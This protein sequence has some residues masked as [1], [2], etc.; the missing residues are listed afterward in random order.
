MPSTKTF[1][2]FFY[3]VFPQA[4]WSPY[5][6][7][8]R[9]VGIIQPMVLLSFDSD[10]DEDAEAAQGLFERLN[11][12]DIPVTFAVPGA[13]LKHGA[14]IYQFLHKQGAHFINHGGGPHTEFHDGR[15]WSVGFY[16]HKSPAQVRQ[17]I[18]LGHSIFKDV[19]GQE[20]R[21][22]RTPHFGHFQRN[23]DL[24]L[25]HTELN[26][27]GGYAFASGSL[28]YRARR[29]GPLIPM[30]GLLEIPVLGTYAWPTRLF[31]SYG[32]LVSKADR[33]VT[34]SYAHQ[35]LKSIQEFQQRG[36]PSLLNYYADPSHVVDNAAYFHVLEQVYSLG[37]K[38]VSFEDVL[39]LVKPEAAE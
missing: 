3:R 38:F 21:G 4:F 12:L 29:K 27:L 36:I 16:N 8:A 31:D 34:D 39:Q 23:Q 24:A 7:R 11:I 17:D 18:R 1:S 22:F 13:Q 9:Q 26:R 35:L 32:Y 19:L 14:K 6:I 37:A 5:S 33:R 2:N 15:Y 28:A 25:I 10:T 30:H 20:P